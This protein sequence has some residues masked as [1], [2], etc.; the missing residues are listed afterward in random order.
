MNGKKITVYHASAGSGK[1]FTLALN[2]ITQLLETNNTPEYAYRHILAVT[3]TNDAANEMKERILQ[4]LDE[5]AHKKYTNKK[6]SDYLKPLIEKLDI[7]ENEI[8]KRAKVAQKAILLDYGNFNICTID[9]FL[10]KVLRNLTVELGISSKFDIEIDSEFPIRNAVKTM[11]NSVKDGDETFER[12]IDFVEYKLEN[13]KWSIERDLRNFAENI[14]KEQFQKYEN[15]INTD[16]QERNWEIKETIK[17]CREFIS[18]YEKT[19]INFANDFFKMELPDEEFY[20]KTR[21]VPSFFKKIKNKDF[22]AP[23]NYVGKV[24]NGENGN[25]ADMLCFNLLKKTENYR[26][27]NEKKYNS[28]RLFLKFIYQLQL[29]SD[30]SNKINEQSKDMNRFILGNVNQLLSKFVK[31]EDASFIFEK[32]GANIHSIVIDE[33]QDTSQLQWEI[34]KNLIFGII[35]PQGNFAMLVGDVKQSI[36]RFRNGDWRILNDIK[37]EFEKRGYKENERIE[38]KSLDVNYRSLKNIVEF[39]NRVFSYSAEILQDNDAKPF[40]K[41]YGDVIKGIKYQNDC[42]KKG[43]FSVDF[44]ERSGKGKSKDGENDKDYDD[45]VME[46]IAQKIKLLLDKGVKSNDICILC[47]KNKQ[48]ET[49]ARKLPKKLPD[50]LSSV[51]IVSENAYLFANSK[52]LKMIIFALKIILNPQDYVSM[53][54]LCINLGKLEAKDVNAEKCL[55]ITKEIREEFSSLPLYDLIVKLCAFFKFETEKNSAFLFAFMD[56]VLDF[57]SKNVSDVGAFID[58]WEEKLSK[59]TLPLPTKERKDNEILAM[60]IH[61]SKGLEFHS[62]IIPFCDWELK[63]HSNGIKQNIVWC[64]R[65]NKEKPF[66]FAL[67]PIEYSAI[68][69][70][71]DFADEY[72]QETIYSQMDN[73]NILY[74]ALTR[75]KNNLCVIAQ[76]LSDKPKTVPN[77]VKEFLNVQASCSV[78]D[79][80]PHENQTEVKEICEKISNIAFVQKERTSDNKEFIART[81]NESLAVGGNFAQKTKEGNLIHKIFENVIEF[82]DIENAVERLV[83]S[84]EIDAEE[85]IKTIEKIETY[86]KEQNKERWFAKDFEVFNE[87]CIIA[88]KTVYRP[89]RIMMNKNGDSVI[90]VD[91]KSGKQDEMHKSQVKKYAEILQRMGYKKVIGYIWYLSENKIVEVK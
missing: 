24:L 41:A 37:D 32:I 78:D 18:Q 20:Q 13:S 81:I 4:K 11:I 71:S 48:I 60:T 62:V 31:E 57:V 91:Y 83:S 63:E 52:E 64:E 70:N 49:I 1:T 45:I 26:Y 22:N 14:F 88:D 66:N 5:L 67:L 3:F 90:V 39:N 7:D 30:I 58:F 40:K 29:L 84:G 27:T 15:K 46:M 80:A 79:I 82:S 72:A 73:L 56:N 16:L 74:V 34:F 44:T 77:N 51:K 75:A 85:K 19:M 9:G 35:L 42:V 54:N 8:A 76:K 47:R 86:I 33:F 65:E 28:S 59:K 69:G 10:Q 61:K 23:N 43:F 50:K 87:S 25:D 12:L 89:D 21:G 68:M 38:Y 55:E 53:A 6:P 2:Y 17:N 36:Y